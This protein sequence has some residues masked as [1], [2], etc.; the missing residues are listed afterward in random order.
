MTRLHYDTRWKWSA[1]LL[2]QIQCLPRGPLDRMR[3]GD[4]HLDPQDGLV[5]E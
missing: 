5:L 3:T 1:K 4:G 2:R